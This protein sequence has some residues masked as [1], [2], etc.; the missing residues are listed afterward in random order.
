[1]GDVL[2][3]SC[4]IF[5]SENAKTN[6]N[7]FG[8]RPNTRQNDDNSLTVPSPQ[9]IFA[10]SHFCP[11]SFLPFIMSASPSALGTQPLEQFKTG[12]F[13]TRWEVSKTLVSLGA[14]VIEPLIAIFRET[15][16]EPEAE[17]DWELPWFI[18]RILGQFSDARSI[19]LLTEVVKTHP[20]E[21]VTSMAALSLA[22]LGEAALPALHAL[23][24]EP[25]TCLFAVAAIAQ[26][27]EAKA[28]DLLLEVMQNPNP[29][30]RAAAIEALSGFLDD[31]I[32]ALFAQALKDPASQVRRAAI[33]GVGLRA[34]QLDS[35]EVVAQL[36][37]LLED[38]N[39]SVAQ[40]AAIAL[41]R[42]GT[43]GAVTGLIQGLSIP[44][45]TPLYLEII[46]SLGAVAS[47]AALNALEDYLQHCSTLDQPDQAHLVQ[48]TIVVLGRVESNPAKLKATQI[49]MQFLE[50]SDPSAEVKQRAALSLGQLGQLEALD[51]LVQLLADPQAG[52]QFHAIAALKRLP[53]PQT[54]TALQ[55]LHQQ[56]KLSPALA[57]G[58]ALALQEWNL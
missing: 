3:F 25:E 4:W 23:M 21:E 57:E 38:L 32:P 44:F 27:R 39:L 54:L 6:G 41:G 11:F 46:R 42:I 17:A 2:S 55:A 10:L 52:V 13:Q 30:I 37:P 18:V 26:V 5:I 29:Q 22:K 28:I 31:R 50:K 48:E 20:S 49:L 19:P 43:D 40:Q 8:F 12:D 56:P 34:T 24:Q 58:I 33:V 9:V 15:T 45:P 7:C 47:S 16:T 36:I 14:T 1:M 51:S 35:T 53:V